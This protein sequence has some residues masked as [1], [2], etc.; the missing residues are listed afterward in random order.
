MERVGF[1][2]LRELGMTKLVILPE[3]SQFDHKQVTV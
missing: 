3:Q 1:A 2:D